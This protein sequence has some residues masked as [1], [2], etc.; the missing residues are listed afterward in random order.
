MGGNNKPVLLTTLLVAAG[1]VTA[2]YFYLNYVR[3]P[4]FK[5]EET[6]QCGAPVPVIDVLGK[7]NEAHLQK[8]VIVTYN[9]FEELSHFQQELNEA[10]SNVSSADDSLTVEL[11]DME[12]EVIEDNETTECETWILP[13]QS[14]NTK[15][16]ALQVIGDVTNIWPKFLASSVNAL[17]IVYSSE[18]SVN[19]KTAI[20]AL[21]CGD[22]NQWSHVPSDT[23]YKTG[24]SLVS[25]K[26]KFLMAFSDTLFSYPVVMITFPGMDLC[27]SDLRT[28]LTFLATTSAQIDVEAHA[29]F[30]AAAQSCFLQIVAYVDTIVKEKK[31]PISQ[32]QILC[33]GHSL[34]GAV[35]TLCAYR[36]VTHYFAA[37]NSS[38]N[39]L[40]FTYGQPKSIKSSSVAQY[41]R[42]V[43]TKN[44]V[45]FVTYGT[46]HSDPSSTRNYRGSTAKD[47]VTGFRR[48]HANARDSIGLQ[49]AGTEVL[50]NSGV[51]LTNQ[52]FV[53]STMRQIAITGGVNVVL[54]SATQ[55]FTGKERFALHNPE[56]YFAALHNYTRER[57]AAVAN[58]HHSGRYC[59]AKFMMWQEKWWNCCAKPDRNAPFCQPGAVRVHPGNWHSVRKFWDCCGNKNRMCAGCRAAGH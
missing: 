50:L 26:K 37:N 5:D 13:V 7:E 58:T 32:L 47:P 35:A 43:L 18:P 36:L 6:P 49:H 14:G 30:V 56:V 9:S 2:A 16:T 20:S 22:S 57:V 51:R 45:R 4:T 29:G 31:L 39:V 55:L 8:E 34:G 44:Y 28:V 12:F 46:Y 23:F 10:V 11:K 17:K 54:A 52:P 42:T 25:N 48:K 53:S 33:C 41:T 19:G 21:N 1:V 27:L 38:N 24:G 15:L 59:D 40:V 3:K